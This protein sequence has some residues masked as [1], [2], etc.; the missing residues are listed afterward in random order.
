MKGLRSTADA[1]AR[2]RANMA[3]AAASR[4]HATLRARGEGIGCLALE[5]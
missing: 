4:R 1:R 5:T 3:A 2:R